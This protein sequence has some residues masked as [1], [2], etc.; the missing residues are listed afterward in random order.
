MKAAG[1]RG[2][3][4]AART[5]KVRAP[6]AA[7]EGLPTERPYGSVRETRGAITESRPGR[8]YV[9]RLRGPATGNKFEKWCPADSGA[10]KAWRRRR[11]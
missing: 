8:P 5:G 7:P 2:P 1:P 3:G 4:Q 11:R 10:R 6:T 9:G